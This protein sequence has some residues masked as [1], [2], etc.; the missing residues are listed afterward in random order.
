[1]SSKA[2]DFDVRYRDVG[3][4]GELTYGRPG[5]GSGQG[6]YSNAG[7]IDN[8]TLG[9]RWYP[10]MSSRGGLAWTQEYSRILNIGAAPLS[11]L[12]DTRDSY[13]MGFDFD[14]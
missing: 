5:A 12:N 10:I 2:D 3:E 14:F 4:T 8:W 7:N 1:M 9:Y 13:L 6:G 11:G